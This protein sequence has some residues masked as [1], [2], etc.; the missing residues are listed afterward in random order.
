[1]TFLIVCFKLHPNFLN[2]AEGFATVTVA[3]RELRRGLVRRETAC[4]LPKILVH[5]TSGNCSFHKVFLK[6]KDKNSM[7]SSSTG[8]VL[9]KCDKANQFVF[10]TTLR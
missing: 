7:S 2:Y 4:Y 8:K 1:M 6:H 3:R 9:T 5:N 10:M